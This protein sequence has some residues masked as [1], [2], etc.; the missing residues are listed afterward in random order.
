MTDQELK[1]IYDYAKL[2]KAAMDV[3]HKGCAGTV[4]FLCIDKN[5]YEEDDVV[6]QACDWYEFCKLRQEVDK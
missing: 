4:D 2:G 6:C 1:T 5:D 3:V